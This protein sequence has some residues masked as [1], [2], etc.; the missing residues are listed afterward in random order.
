MLPSW[1]AQMHPSLH[2][3]TLT[4]AHKHVHIYIYIN[5]D[6]LE[7]PHIVFSVESVCFL[8]YVCVIACLHMRVST[9]SN[10]HLSVADLKSSNYSVCKVKASCRQVRVWNK[11]SSFSQMCCSLCVIT[12]FA[13]GDVSVFLF[14]CVLTNL[15]NIRHWTLPA[16]WTVS[17]WGRSS[18]SP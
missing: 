1:V 11:D 15:W 12:A 4:H 2:S 5:P 8:I 9:Q 7:K 17:V 16:I 18:L 14:P 10:L 13:F 3:H 6:N